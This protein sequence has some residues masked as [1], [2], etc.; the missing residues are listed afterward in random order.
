ME[1]PEEC[2]PEQCL[3]YAE[4]CERIAEKNSGEDREALL[5]IARAWR[6][7]AQELKE[8]K[9]TTDQLARGADLLLSRGRSVVRPAIASATLAPV[10]AVRR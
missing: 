6:K 2:S 5:R 7:C 8:A 3:T 9:E 10:P 1:S 4:E